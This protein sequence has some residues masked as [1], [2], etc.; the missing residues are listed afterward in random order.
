MPHRKARTSP[1]RLWP[2]LAVNFF[3][4]DMQ[5]GIG[6]FVGVFLQLHGWTSG[7]IGTAL[8]L[9]NVAGMLITTPI[10]GCIDT[11][12]HKRAWVIVP[13]IA[14]VVAS[15]VIL[16]S[17]SFWAVALSQVATSIAG[18]AIVPAVTG[19]TLGIV[20][21][22]GFNRQNG[23]NQAFSHGGN[24][25]GA[26]AS[27]YLGWQYGYVAVFVLAAL[28]GAITIASVLLI[29]PDSIDHRA[30]RGKEEDPDS[31]PSGF[32]VLVKHKPLLVL[33]VALAAFHLGNAAIVPLYGLAAVAGNHADGPSFVATTI[34]V[35]QA[36]MIVASIAG[37]HAAERRNY[38]SVLLLSF[39][40]LPVR[41]VLACFL[42]GWWG[43]LPVQI[44]DGIG[45]G[46]QSVAVPGMVARS[47]NGTGRVNLGQGA[48]I[49]IQGI[50]AS[51]SPALGGWIAQWVGYGPAFLVLGGLG[52][53][54]VAFWIAFRS[55]VQQY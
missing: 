11:T 44:L 27:G 6:P 28:F 39:L 51:L 20:K 1:A 53:L 52:L 14:V 12:N 35:A 10:G 13:G 9:G 30:A 5:S 50:G 19:I 3:M 45:A 16:M 36:V 2:L 8:T 33:A 40:A 25:V 43:V 54:S 22:R 31:Q 41:G 23:R 47:L 34:V 24:M 18:A 29:P 21:Q 4:A 17:Q 48:V 32:S 15:A 55:T 37:M 42:S 46:L 49:T 26:A 7:L 38:W